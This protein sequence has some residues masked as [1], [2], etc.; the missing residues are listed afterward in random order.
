MKI[1]L[2]LTRRQ[3]PKLLVWAL[4]FSFTF[5]YAQTTEIK[6]T[7]IAEG[8][9]IGGVNVII[10]GTING[11][12]TD[13][14]GNYTI[15]VEKGNTLVYSYVGYKT[16]EILIADQNNINVTLEP[17]AAA[18]Q[19]VIVIGYGTQKK[20]EVTGAVVNISNDVI[21]KTATSDLGTALQGQVAGVNIQ[22][23]SGRPGEAANVQIRGLGSVSPN[24]L[25]P[26]YVVDGIPYEDNPNI[27]P[28]LISS[29]DILKDGAAASIYGTR[30]SNGVILITTKKGKSGSIKVDFNTY[31]SI[32]D[33]TSGTPL[34]NTQQQI[35]AENVMLKAL[36]R[37]PLIFFFNPDALDYDSDFV[38]DVQNDGAPIRNYSLGVSGGSEN[39]TLSF[40]TNYF[41][42]EGI[43]VNSGFDRLTTRFTGEF[44]KNKFK[45]FATIGYTNENREQEPWGLYEYSIAQKPWQPPLTGL[46]SVGGNGVEIPVRNAILYSYLSQQLNNEDDR[47]TTSV[48]IAANLQYEFFDGFT[49]KINL[50]RNTYD[51]SR[52]F[53]QPQYLVYDK[54]GL[55]PTASRE[56][57]KLEE[58]Y[59]STERNVIEN[60][61]TYKKSFGKHNLNFL[62]VL[63]YE[64][65]KSKTLGLG[66]NFSE[67][68][69]NSSKTLGAGSDPIAPTS[70]IDERKLAG[71]L[72]RV[73][74]NFDEKYLFSASYRRDGSSRFSEKNRYGDFFGFS[75]GWN[76]HEENFFQNVSFVN[77]FKLRLSYAELGNQN[78]PS[79]SY[80]PS[81]E[82]GVNY[83]FGSNESL[84]F[85]LTQRRFVDPNIKWETTISKN[86]GVDLTLLDNKLNITVDV[87]QNDKKD[88]LLEER[89]P[90]SAG[91]YHPNTNLYDTKVIN[92]GNMV[93][94]GIEL[95]ASFKNRSKKGDFGYTISATFTKND[96]EVTS[97][98]GTTRGYGNGAPS[99]VLA[100]DIDYTTFLAEGYEAGAFFLVQ[101]D[102][103]IKTQEQ[104][105]AYKVIDKSAQLGDMMYKDIDGNNVID[106]NDRVYSGS[107]QADFEAGLSLNLDYKN[108]DFYIQSYFSKGAEIY[109]GA[110]YYAYTQGRHLEQF[111]MWS[112]QNP[113]SDIPTDRQNAIH[114]NVRS[115]SDYFLEDGTYFRIR[116]ISL[117]YTLKDLP[118]F[119]LNS[120][121]IYVS[122]TNPFTFTEYTGYDPEVGGDGIFTRGIDKGNY[123]VARQFLLGVQLH[124]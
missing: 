64:D 12:Y 103:V 91:T 94:K 86:I 56:N 80:I 81:I 88:M 40:N 58:N 49:Y 105:D 108:F 99:T 61:F 67:E 10:K 51:Y 97:L 122:A 69:G 96:N 18:L 38:G 77:Q 6:G 117:G 63:S 30:A 93:N 19:E 115:R 92:A 25:G 65:F 62:A 87:Y 55:N 48:N 73:Q 29:V 34:M 74:Y 27:S 35:Y 66:V 76:I 95:A 16:K 4:F 104:L 124:F 22:A 21:D 7:V 109:N 20:K 78:I 24:A 52:S 119:G 116:N 118:A 113:D 32:Q 15:K 43:L 98:N 84:S 85:G 82:S 3:K 11:T 110:K 60:M 123:P 111:Y 114:N 79:Y 106:D 41:N 83:P 102:G 54:D 68:S 31:T 17:D 47:K 100:N 89:L 13:F 90:A 75:T 33:I 39:L 14:D 42:Q 53:F 44:R 70:Y 9:P 28:E 107:G 72:G 8:F 50:G 5:G 2:N 120:A 23:S 101:H 46:N 121:R 59:I 45:A 71:K 1:K 26:L 37:D 57:A 36:G 112:P